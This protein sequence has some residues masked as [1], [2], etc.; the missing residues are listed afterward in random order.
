MRIVVSMQLVA[1][2]SRYTPKVTTSAI[3]M[4]ASFLNYN[5]I[6]EG[7]GWCNNPVVVKHSLVA[8]YSS[9]TRAE[10][11]DDFGGVTEM[12]SLPM[13]RKKWS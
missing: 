4:F 12:I 8:S 10:D 1:D 3:S 11:P 2:A 13:L 7:V 6:V 5:S 9:M